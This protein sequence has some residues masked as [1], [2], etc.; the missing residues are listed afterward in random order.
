MHGK[1]KQSKKEAEK[2]PELLE[3]NKL[4]CVDLTIKICTAEATLKDPGRKRISYYKGM[5]KD[6]FLSNNRHA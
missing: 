5:K 2:R 3:V 1:A 4:V 6:A